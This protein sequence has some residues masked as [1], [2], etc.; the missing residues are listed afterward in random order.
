[1]DLSVISYGRG[2]CRRI[3]RPIFFGGKFRLKSWMLLVCFFSAAL[4]CL[5]QVGPAPGTLEATLLGHYR[6]AEWGEFDAARRTQKSTSLRDWSRS[7][8]LV[9]HSYLARNSE[10]LA[11][12]AMFGSLRFGQLLAPDSINISPGRVAVLR[13]IV[14]LAPLV[15]GSPTIAGSRLGV[16]PYYGIRNLGVALPVSPGTRIQQASARPCR[17]LSVNQTLTLSQ[18]SALNLCQTFSAGGSQTAVGSC[19]ASGNC[20]FALPM[21]VMFCPII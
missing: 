9:G 7:M 8:Q 11:S 12:S 2:R 4:P 21:S 13:R 5:G 1:M 19:N 18:G 14:D 15:S 6:L 17:T 20:R 10:L 16:S 3:A